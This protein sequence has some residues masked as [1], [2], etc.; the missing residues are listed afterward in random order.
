VAER[1]SFVAEP[2]EL[3]FSEELPVREARVWVHPNKA[4][5][6][7]VRVGRIFISREDFERFKGKEVRL[8]HLF[9]VVFDARARAR[10][11]STE[12]KDVPK[13]N[14]VSEHVSASV[15]MP[16]G[17]FV[18]GLAERAIERLKKLECV[19]FERFGFVSYQGKLKKESRKR[20]E[21]GEEH[22]FWF[23]HK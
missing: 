18:R 3:H 21:E 4:K 16:D 12:V 17:K 19:Q 20:G 6:R 9:N 5:E 11:T 23:A 7:R 2:V 14:W 15:L 8:L 22:E 13:I 1:Y 10:V